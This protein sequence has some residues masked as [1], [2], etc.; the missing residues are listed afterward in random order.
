VF[1]SGTRAARAAVQEVHQ[2]MSIAIWVVPGIVGVC[3][4]VPVLDKVLAHPDKPEMGIFFSWMALTLTTFGSLAG[5]TMLTGQVTKGNMEE[6]PDEHD[7]GDVADD[8]VDA[9]TADD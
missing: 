9:F 5:L 7:W 3:I 1:R 8:A 4:G 6:L 2:A